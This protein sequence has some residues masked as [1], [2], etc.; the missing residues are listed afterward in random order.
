MIQDADLLLLKLIYE[1]RIVD[2]ATLARCMTIHKSTHGRKPL[3][4]TQAAEAKL[5]Q[6][7]LTRTD[8]RPGLLLNIDGGFERLAEPALNGG[9][10]IGKHHGSILIDVFSITEK[11]VQLKV[12]V[13]LPTVP[14]PSWRK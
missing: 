14:D 13:L 6:N 5:D 10:K 4:K 1:R 11:A 8:F 12:R 7:V 3:I 2:G 9:M